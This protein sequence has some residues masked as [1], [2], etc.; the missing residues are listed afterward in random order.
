M[1]NPNAMTTLPF[2]T[3]ASN[4]CGVVTFS[5]QY[6]A[7]NHHL[8]KKKDYPIVPK[9]IS[10]YIRAMIKAHVTVMCPPGDYNL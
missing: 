8:S 4:I 10:T 7:L 3:G 2:G 5:P 1:I 6:D 9:K